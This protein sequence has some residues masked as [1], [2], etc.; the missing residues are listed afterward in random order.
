MLLQSTGVRTNRYYIP[1]FE[2]KAGEIVV[3]FLYN[4]AHYHDVK[5][6]LKNIFTGKIKHDHVTINSTFAFADYF[7][8]PRFRRL[9][10]PVTVGEYLRTKA[11]PANS[12][13]EKI[14]ESSGVT[15]KTKVNSLAAL[16]RKLLSI[17]TALSHTP[18]IVF[19]LVGLGADSAAIVY[20]TVKAIVNTGGSAILLDN[21]FDLQNDC[22][23]YIELEW[24][25]PLDKEEALKSRGIEFK[26]KTKQQK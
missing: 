16:P 17:Y 24:L 2:L 26:L 8:E 22:S 12:I 18:N 4:G 20:K 11:N 15:K 7:L 19:D 10:F 21:C 25:D 13:A 14:Y 9:F 1:P 6:E 23:T 3:I 5:M